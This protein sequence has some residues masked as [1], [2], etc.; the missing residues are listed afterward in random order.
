MKEVSLASSPRVSTADRLSDQALLYGSAAFMVVL[1]F[2]TNH[3]YGFHRDE[4]ATLDD[5]RH[6]D[7][8]YVAYPPVTPF[9]GWLSLHI[10][11]ESLPGFRFFATLAT[12]AG[13]LLTGLMARQLGGGR[14]AQL[15]AIGGTLA[16]SLAAGSLMQ[17]V[18]FDYFCWILLIYFF[19][20][21]L[22]SDDQRWWVA[23]GAA[24]GLGMLTKYSMLFCVGGLAGA[25]AVAGRWRDLTS[26]WF[27][28][29]VLLSLLVFLPN[30]IWQLRNGF[31]SLDFLRHIHERDI[32]I[33]RTRDFLPDQLK[34]ALFGLPLALA[35][36]WFFFG[37]RAGRRFRPAGLFYLVP[38]ILFVIARGRG[39]YLAAAY[40]LLYASGGVMVERWLEPRPRSMCKAVWALVLIGLAANLLVVLALV[41]PLAPINSSWGKKALQTN[42]DL[43]EE[44]GWPDLVEAVAAVRDS[45]PSEEHARLGILVGNYGE[46]GAINLYGPRF[47]L[48]AAIAGVNSFW[49]RGYGNPPPV[50][51][52]AIGLS[53]KFLEA[54]FAS[55]QLAGHV[56]NRY[57]VLNEETREHPDIFICRGL[58]GSWDE[59]W[60]AFRH[61]G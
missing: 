41:M 53:R 12:A 42:D 21:L 25:F 59:L 31:I 33:G 45:I 20:R 9:F 46:G 35:G 58:R 49:T 55:C 3:G 16:F 34:I 4:L 2:I 6:L 51:V 17:Y 13:T 15:L 57:G 56:Q 1:L 37:A 36:L 27:W 50:T 8:G 47:G 48:P 26:R 30:L 29:G 39:Y 52:V 10:F 32:R 11:G 24:I 14:V 23:I 60:A 7:W 43:A 5:A 40:P 28:F 38:F 54:K 22:Q 18:A 44:I 61:Y 19:I